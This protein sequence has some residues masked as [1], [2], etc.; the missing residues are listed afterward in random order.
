MVVAIVW[1]L[2]LTWVQ[3][4]ALRKARWAEII[5]RVFGVSGKTSLRWEKNEIV[6]SAGAAGAF[7]AMLSAGNMTLLFVQISFYQA[8]KSQHILC[9]LLM[10]YFIF[11]NHQPLKIVL[12]SLGVT[13]GIAVATLA[14]RDILQD[15]SKPG[16]DFQMELMQ[17]LAAGLVSRYPIDPGY[18]QA[19]PA[20]SSSQINN[21]AVTDS[22]SGTDSFF[23]ALYPILLERS[24]LKGADMWQKSININCM[25]VVWYIPLIAYEVFGQDMLASPALRQVRFWVFNFLTGSVG[26]SLNI[27]AMLHVRYTSVLPRKRYTHRPARTHVGMRQRIFDLLLSCT[28]LPTELYRIANG[29]SDVL[30]PQSP[31]YSVITLWSLEQGSHTVLTLQPLTHMIAGSIKGSVTTVISVMLFGDQMN[32]QGI[33]GLLLVV[34]SSF[35]YSY[36]RRYP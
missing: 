24:F 21:V 16:R 28:L 31:T 36:F 30:I 13:I 4:L 11:G 29:R 34:V 23:V 3:R 32:A 10:G 22:R 35:A 14:E 1:L 33:L 27:V 17:G 6:A 8:A 12:S 2:V 15:M 5:V 26:F 7:T 19:A 18:D 20:A 9:N 25:S